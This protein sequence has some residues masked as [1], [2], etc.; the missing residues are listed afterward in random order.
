[1]HD[2][3]GEPSS[4]VCTGSKPSATT[5]VASTDS[6][7]SG[8]DVSA[9][10]RA[11]A[12]HDHDVDQHHERGEPGEHDER[13]RATSRRDR[14]RRPR[15][16]ASCLQCARS[17]DARGRGCP[18]PRGGAGRTITR[19]QPGGQRPP[20]VRP[21]RSAR[22]PRDRVCWCHAA[23]HGRRPTQ[24]NTTC[25]S[26]PP[27][28]PPP[29]SPTAAAAVPSGVTKLYGT[30]DA[31][32]T[33]L[34]DVS[35]G[36]GQG[37][38]TAIMGPSGSGKST[39]LH[40]LAGLD[41]PTSGEVYLGDTE[42]TSLNDKALT[43]LRRDRI[44]FI[45][46]SFNLL[47]T[48]TAAENIVLP[49]RIAGRKPDDALGGLDRRDRR[50]HR[51]ARP[52][53]RGALR[54]PAAAGRRGPGPGLAARRSSSPTSPPAPSTRG[55]APSCSRSSA[56]RSTS[57]ARPSS[58]S[59]TTRTPRA[60]PT[61]CIFL[62]D[63]HIV[64]EMHAADRRRRPRLHEAPGSLT[65][66]TAT[67]RG[68][69]AHKL[70]LVLT[71]ASIA[72]GVAFLAGHA[73]PDRHH[74][75][76]L[77]A[78]LRQGLVRHR[79]GRPHRGAVHRVRGR[80]HQP[81][82]DRRVGPRRRSATST[83]SARPRAR[84]A[85]TRCSPTTTARPSLTNGGAP[86]MGYSMPADEELRGDVEL[87]SGTAPD[88]RA[89]GRHR[90]HQRRGARHRARLHDQG[91]VPGPDPGVHRRRHRRLRRREGPRRHHVGVL[92]HRDRPAGARQPRACSTR[93]TSAPTEGVSQA[94]LAERL[95][96]GR[97]RRH[98]GRDRRDR[99]RRRTPTRSRRTSRSSASCS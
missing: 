33:A 28:A 34:D 12:E 7:T 80:R 21:A 38:F 19:R 29:R 59:P 97:A 53:T 48:M 26:S 54:R 57:S 61:G 44:G 88:Q 83:A 73:R 77:R 60:T 78:A 5:A 41:R 87:L 45:F 63:G 76:R 14:R 17:R 9:Q 36:L 32:V 66:L 90:R 11:A 25:P 27:P 62:A 58:W 93:S 74:G 91:A 95:D 79:R 82:P 72:L 75:A 84:S 6:A 42:I 4:R 71:T 81:G 65:M 13:R 22:R 3:C 2:P 69:V 50:P 51:P 40:M 24:E 86:T 35:V 46:Q 94:E 92:R 1:M 18:N 37:E 96:R 47:P 23:R 31:A 16:P 68:M 30:G 70:R 49:M 98:R 55:P 20:A 43:L 8:D 99:R 52:P 85:A 10:Q 39:L 64:D 56:R 67:L 15:Q 89:R